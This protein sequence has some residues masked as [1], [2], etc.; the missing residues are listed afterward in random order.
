MAE[1]KQWKF[2]GK[3][4]I[5]EAGP[6][7]K[8]ALPPEVLEHLGISRGGD[9]DVVFF[10]DENESRVVIFNSKDINFD[11]PGGEKGGLSFKED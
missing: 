3:R 8:V 6:S 5:S 2:V 9:Q 1:G 10:V 7:L 4:K 11:V